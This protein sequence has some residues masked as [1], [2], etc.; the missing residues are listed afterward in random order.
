MDFLRST[1]VPC[2]TGMIL[3]SILSA[4]LARMGL[5]WLPNALERTLG[6]EE[7]ELKLKW[8]S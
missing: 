1:D 3:F 5:S 7:N 4:L 6:M 8:S 2:S